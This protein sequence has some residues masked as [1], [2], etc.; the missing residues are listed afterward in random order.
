[1]VLTLHSQ[2]KDWAPVTNSPGLC[3][4]GWRVNVTSLCAYIQQV[5]MSSLFLSHLF[6]QCS[7]KSTTH[8]PLY[9]STVSYKMMGSVLTFGEF[10]ICLRNQTGTFL[11]E[12]GDFDML[13]FTLYS[14]CK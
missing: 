6:S 1:M 7:D 4:I 10:T 3:S 12:I 5:K 2:W 14:N 11:K 8:E 9:L 13:K